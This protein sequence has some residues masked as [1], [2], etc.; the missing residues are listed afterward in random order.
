MTS[1]SSDPNHS[2]PLP[3]ESANE[4]EAGADGLAESSA[5][6]PT[7]DASE[8]EHGTLQP[9]PPNPLKRR[10]DTDA[11]DPEGAHVCAPTDA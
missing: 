4:S 9:Q 7:E 11:G 5:D 1:R 8:A 6:A 3:P 2:S 10:L